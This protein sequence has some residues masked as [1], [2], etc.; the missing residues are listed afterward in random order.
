M[1]VDVVVGAQFGD[2]GKGMVACLLANEAERLHR[3]YGWTA[4]V[5]AQNAEHRFIRQGCPLTARIF[6][7]AAAFRE[8]IVAVLGAGHCFRPEHFFLEAAH[9][10]IPLDRVFVDSQAMWLKEEHAEENLQLANARGS[11]GW[12]VGCALAEKVRRSPKTKLIGD[13]VE[14]Q[15]ALGDRLA[16][17][18]M[19][20]PLLREPGLLEGSQGALLSLDQGYFPYCT[21]KNV[22][23]PALCAELGIN[24]KDIRK[25]WGVV[26]AVPM[27]VPGPSGP[28]KGQEVSFDSV[29]KRVGVRL[30]DY[31]RR[32]GDAH[33]WDSRGGQERLFEFSMEELRLSH[34]LNGFDYLVLTFTD[35]HRPGNYRVR[36]WGDLHPDTQALVDR[37]SQA[38]APVVLVRTGPGE[39]DNIWL[40]DPKDLI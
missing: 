2:E 6:P 35:Y 18:P 14:M 13:C 9:L 27:R 22:T 40:E 29:E 12:G 36:R 8:G 17:L 4:R 23:V 1:K 19:I 21:G 15:R 11:T 24:H 25:V 32:Q 26:R 31:V 16:R 7:S 28:S 38:I 5:G 37:I 20:L 30:P 39:H 3:P 10:G 34:R 33:R